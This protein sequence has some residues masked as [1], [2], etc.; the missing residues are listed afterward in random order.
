MELNDEEIREFADI[1][2]K[3]F[4]ED[5]TPDKARYNASRLLELFWLLTRPLPSETSEASHKSQAA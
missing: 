4:N 3:E 2:K 1:W 5:L